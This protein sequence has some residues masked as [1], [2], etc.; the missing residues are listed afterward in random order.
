M[1]Q[2]IYLQE[3]RQKYY[4]EHIINA[5]R[6]TEYERTTLIYLP[7]WFPLIVAEEIKIKVYL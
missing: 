2:I 7:M 4:L 1:K 3:R 5:P 6:F